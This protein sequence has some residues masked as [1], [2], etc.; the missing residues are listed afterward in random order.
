VNLPIR[1]ILFDHQGK[2]TPLLHA[3]KGHALQFPDDPKYYSRLG[4][5]L[6]SHDVQGNARRL[7]R[8]H[9]GGCKTFFLYPHTARPNIINDIF[10]NASFTTA[11]F[12]SAEGHIEVLRRYGVTMPIHATGWYLCPLREFRSRPSV[13]KILFAPIHPRCAEIDQQVNFRTWEILYSL[14][15]KGAIDLTVRYVNDLVASGLEQVNDGRVKYVRGG[16]DLT[17]GEIDN[18]DVVVGH[19]TYAWLAVA[20]GVPTVMMDEEMPTHTS[21]RKGPSSFARNWKKYKDLIMYPLDILHTDDPMALMERA[22]GS[23]SSIMDWK[24]RMIGEAFD[25]AKFIEVIKGYA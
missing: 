25:P 20:R 3:L 1:F 5:V 16:L 21:P 22:A 8:I 9:D 11:Q 13:R 2:G 14:V 18:A 24:K 6:A 19:Q 4:F 10:P 12:V 7:Q 15:Q 23:D 17:Y